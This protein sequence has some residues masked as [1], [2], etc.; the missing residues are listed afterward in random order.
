M[1][2]PVS[3][4]YRSFGTVPGLQVLGQGRGCRGWYHYLFDFGGFFVRRIVVRVIARPIGAG[5]VPLPCI[6]ITS[7]GTR[8]PRTEAG[9]ALLRAI[10]D[11]M[12]VS[13]A[14]AYSA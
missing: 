3:D 9:E 1:A 10:S 4:R 12:I 2:E 13:A 6:T 5:G 11:L 7:S 8:L 14:D